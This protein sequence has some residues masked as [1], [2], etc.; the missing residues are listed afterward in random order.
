MSAPRGIMSMTV[1]QGFQWR[2]TWRS[3]ALAG[4]LFMVGSSS[5]AA[6][7]E[8]AFVAKLR[9]LIQS[10]MKDW[11]TPGIMVLVDVPGQSTWI[12]GFGTSDLATKA[13]HHRIGSV[14]K[15]LTGE[16]V[17]L[18]VD[19]GKIGLDDPVEKY[20]P[21]VVPNGANI[22]IRQMLDMTSGIYNGTE[23]PDFNANIDAKPETIWTPQEFIALA[24]KHPPYFAPGTGFHYSN[25][26]YELLGLIVEK[27]SGMALDN[28]M[29]ERIFR[30]LGMTSTILPK[31]N[32]L[33]AS[34]AHRQCTLLPMTRKLVLDDLPKLRIEDGLVLAGVGCAL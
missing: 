11:V 6:N 18:L 14:T 2:G 32:R 30:P 24:L 34:A 23:D 1:K 29:A 20:L 22:T 19:E 5:C 16:A 17:L 31:A 7:A 26:N 21:G 8:P 12:E 3:L 9:P 10:A 27:Q 13:D 4:S 33:G 28:F 15:T 25:T